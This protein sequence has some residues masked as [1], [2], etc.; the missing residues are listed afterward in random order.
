MFVHPSAN[1]GNPVLTVFAHIARHIDRDRFEVHFAVDSRADGTLPVGD[2]QAVITGWDI[3]TTGLGR[4]GRA[5]PA[6]RAGSVGR[7]ATAIAGLARYVRREGIDILQC[8]ATASGGGIALAV[9]KLARVPLLVHFHDLPG[10]YSGGQG[11]HSPVRRRLQRTIV[12]RADRLVAVSDFIAHEVRAMGVTA[13]P[14]DV[15]PNGVDLSRFNPNVNAARM[16]HEYGIADDEP[17]AL[18]LGRVLES[19]RQQDFVRAF[20]LARRRVPKLRGLAV[21]WDDPRYP[22]SKADLRRLCEEEGLGDAFVIAEGRLEAPELMAA[23]DILVFPALEEAA[24]LVVIEAMAAGK[25]V[26][27]ARSGGTAES[28]VDGETGFLVAPKAPAELADKLAQLA[29]NEGLRRDMGIA[30]RRRAEREYDARLL[31]VRFAPIYEELARQE[32]R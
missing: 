15:V 27:G 10:R 29:S 30:A 7:I 28:I 6:A 19:K 25:P 32:A 12:R 22:L 17:L 24:P 9:A 8:P 5:S 20:A 23:A 16:R 13:S 4:L 18:Q 14:I 31:A 3:A 2:D 11:R 1:L 26:V 21:G